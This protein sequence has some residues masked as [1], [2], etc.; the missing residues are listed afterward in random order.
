MTE[1]SRCSHCGTPLSTGSRGNLCPKCLLKRGLEPNTAGFTADGPETSARWTPPKPEELAARFPE[2]KI[3]ELIGRGGMGAVYKAR[4]KN[5]DRLVAL[6]ILPPEIGRDPAFA[7][8]FAREAQAM[9]RLSHPH[10]VAIHDFGQRDGLFFFL[11]EYMDGLNLGQLMASGN[12]SPKE[13]LAIV[14]QI[15]DA[16]QFAHDQGIVHRDIKPEN[17]LLDRRGQVKIADFGLAK[18]MGQPT[19][20]VTAEKVMG[21][22]QYMAPEQVEHPK[23][24]DPRAD[25]YSLGV[26]F[27]QML[28]GELPL[29]KFE[30]PSHKVLIDVRLDEVVLR[31]LEKEP[32]RRYQQASQ[33]KTEVETILTTS[34]SGSASTSPAASPIAPRKASVTQWV[35]GASLLWVVLLSFPIATILP[36]PWRDFVLMCAPI[37]VL[38]AT[39]ILLG[40]RLFSP[41]PTAAKPKPSVPGPVTQLP[42]SGMS[43]PTSVGHPSARFLRTAI[44]G[45]CWAPAFFIAFVTMFWARAVP[46]GEYHGPEWWQILLMIVVGGLGFTAPFGTTILGCV[47]LSQI[48]R[49]AGKLYGLGLALFDT[50]LFPLLALDVVILRLGCFVWQMTLSGVLDTWSSEISFAGAAFI[51]GTIA[52][53][54]DF[55]IIR[56]AWRAANKPVGGPQPLSA[57]PPSAGTQ[58]K[59]L[60]PVLGIV[61]LVVVV[62]V[63]L[64]GIVVWC[65]FEAIRRPALTRD[66]QAATG[67][68]FGPV[69]ER[70]LPSGAACTAQYFQFHNG[71]I[72]FVGK[73]PSM[74]NEESTRAWKEAAEAGGVDFAA[75]CYEEHIYIIGRGCIFSQE[76]ASAVPM[77]EALELNWDKTTA[78]EVMTSMEVVSGY[79]SIQQPRRE[80]PVTYLFK[81][82]RGETGIIQ[83]LGVVE[84]KRGDAGRGMKFRYKLV[85][86]PHEGDAPAVTPLRGDTILARDVRLYFADPTA[87]D[88]SFHS[89]QSVGFAVFFIP[90]KDLPLLLSIITV[91]P[92]TFSLS[93]H[94]D[95]LEIAEGKQSGKIASYPWPATV[96]RFEKVVTLPVR[97]GDKQYSCP[98]HFELQ[99]RKDGPP[100]GSYW[101][102]AYLS[103]IF[104]SATGDR[105]FEIV[106]LDQEMKFRNSPVDEGIENGVLGID[107]NG[108]GKIGGDEKAG[109]LYAPFRLGAKRY[110]LTEIDPAKLRVAFRE[111]AESNAPERNAGAVSVQAVMATGSLEAT[112]DVPPR[113][114]CRAL[115]EEADIVAVDVGQEVRMTLDAFPKRTFLGKV[116]QVAKTP[117]K[118]PN[119]VLYET[120]IDLADPDPRFKVGMSVNVTFI[121]AHRED[122]P[123]THSVAKPT[124]ITDPAPEKPIR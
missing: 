122:V 24:V 87:R 56:W 23:D 88:G 93:L 121:E 102:C 59:W 95:L 14:P 30:P 12:V 4:Q 25:I 114:V 1:E 103:G 98:V 81:T 101:Y 79:T 40:H 48:R 43:Q 53:A 31:A 111:V 68:T 71:E 11:M 124:A 69:I 54:A 80:L 20:A 120:V 19:A 58:R 96:E 35:I 109:E 94:Q 106:N 63:L 49:S 61:A 36:N 83:I 76:V 113:W 6:K 91:G 67:A 60:A 74:T 17:I 8:R 86:R 117:V 73:G 65:E 115:G 57:T 9:A 27:Y 34:P 10:I 7:E 26:V 55:L 84:D 108:D 45:A 78:E 38:A 18:L 33:V 3:L 51:S 64:V 21:T 37:L 118:E 44:V 85:Q 5:L 90:I 75:A 28:T 39:L 29:E 46:A 97:F 112:T 100:S 62:L 15:C 22:P 66:Q 99:R 47:A 50:L 41:Q 119:A 123:R 89:Q 82:G 52:V 32:D 42:A 104:P 77:D 2:M 105:E 72:L 92:H 16:L 110:R 107:L 13:A 70:V 116:V